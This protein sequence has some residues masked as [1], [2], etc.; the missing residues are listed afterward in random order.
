M[1]NKIINFSSKIKKALS[2]KNG[3]RLVIPA[4]PPKLPVKPTAHFLHRYV[5]RSDNGY[6]S[7]RLL[8]TKTLSAALISPFTILSAAAFPPSAALFRVQVKLLFLITG[9]KICYCYNITD[10]SVCQDFFAKAVSFLLFS[11]GKT[12]FSLSF[13]SRFALAFASI[14]FIRF[15]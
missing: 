4:V 1:V 12:E 11:V 8:L 6:G 14:S 2:H 10:F 5:S 13:S 15:S 7:R 3:T 9:L